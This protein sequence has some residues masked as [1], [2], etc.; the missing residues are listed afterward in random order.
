ML[1]LVF[2]DVTKQFAGR[3]GI[4]HLNAEVQSG[5]ITIVKGTNGSGKSTLL[6]MAAKLLLPDVGKVTAK[7]MDDGGEQELRKEAYRRRLA[8]VTPDFHV[9]PKLTAREN[10]DFF[11]GFRR[12]EPLDDA[13]Y[14]SLLQ[15][16][17]LEEAAVAGKY[18]EHFSTG[19]KKRLHLAILLGSG[20]DIWLLDEPGA[21]LDAEGREMVRREARLAAKEGKLVLW[22]T[23]DPEEEAEAD[24]CIALSGN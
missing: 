22:A 16:V 20:A 18:A 1:K 3:K 5:S 7:V 4:E 24:A 13:E 12:T 8:L 23:N 21:N 17:G 19:M 2:S 9:Y 15:K 10:L 11:L 6:K 14:H